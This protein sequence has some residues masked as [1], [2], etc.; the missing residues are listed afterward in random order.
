M[1]N[2]KPDGDELWKRKQQ[3]GHIRVEVVADQDPNLITTF[4]FLMSQ[5][6]LG[7]RKAHMRVDCVQLGPPDLLLL[8]R[9]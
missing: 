5:I 1:S 7:M 9:L 2:K 4:E 8:L 3:F 6:T